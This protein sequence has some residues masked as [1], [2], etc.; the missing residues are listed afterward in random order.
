MPDEFQALKELI[1]CCVALSPY[2]PKLVTK[3]LVDMSLTSGT[4]Y[5]LIQ[6]T[7]D[8]HLLSALEV[9]AVGANWSIQN[10][11]HYLKGSPGFIL[12]TY[13][14]PLKQLFV[15]GLDKLSPRLF[16]II[17]ELQDYKITVEW[18]HGK[19]HQF[20]DT[21]GCVPQLD[22]WSGFDPLTG[23][24]SEWQQD[25]KSLP[26]G[27][28][29]INFT[30]TVNNVMCQDPELGIQASKNLMKVVKDDIIYQR[31]GKRTKAEL[32]G[33]PRDHPALRYRAVWDTMSLCPLP[34]GSRMIQ[35]DGGRLVD[36]EDV[37]S[38]QGFLLLAYHMERL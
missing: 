35:L 10:A 34:D 11:S 38:S 2:Y 14:Q 25:T 20:V 7:E 17:G 18:T 27:H 9:E 33:L 1:C 12:V 31:V 37:L 22:V 13:H 16:K 36:E 5:M 4:A 21:L 24:Y 23:H 26:S 19:H 32:K 8:G 3:L 6:I 15:G 28:H 29:L 30:R